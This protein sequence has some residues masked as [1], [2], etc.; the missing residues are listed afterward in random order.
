VTTNRWANWYSCD[1]HR[2]DE[3]TLLR[4][5]V[6]CITYY[7]MYVYNVSADRWANWYCHDNHTRDEIKLLRLRVG[8]ITCYSL[9]IIIVEAF[10]FPSFSFLVHFFYEKSLESSH[11]CMYK[12]TL[13]GLCTAMDV[14]QYSCLQKPPFVSRVEDTD[15]TLLLRYPI[16]IPLLDKSLVLSLTA[17]HM[18]LNCTLSYPQGN[19]S[20]PDRRCMW[21][22]L[23]WSMC[24][25]YSWYT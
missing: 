8:C 4:L 3:I 25:Q 14:G 12:C 18:Q 21:R 13:C 11:K 19:W 24:L 2:R 20:L 10:F 22:L 23:H 15:Y 6:G 7:T 17:A 5:R 9:H 1:N 16:L